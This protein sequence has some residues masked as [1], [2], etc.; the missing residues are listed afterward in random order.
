MSPA[1]ASQ[2]DVR[3]M[4]Y[5]RHTACARALRV[6]QCCFVLGNQLKSRCGLL[7]AEVYEDAY[8]AFV[9]DVLYDLPRGSAGQVVCK[10]K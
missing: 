4:S 9:L 5:I 8:V 6:S 2:F 7:N 10:Q 3:L 1:S